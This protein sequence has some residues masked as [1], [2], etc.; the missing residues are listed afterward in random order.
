MNNTTQMVTAGAEFERVVTL[1]EEQARA[2]ATLAGDFNPI[3]HD[4]AFART[5]RFGGLIV[6]GTQT[7]ALMLAMTATYLSGFG[8]CLGLDAQFRFRRGIRMGETVRMV[9]RVASVTPK[10]GL[11][12][13]IK[14]TGTLTVVATNEVA[15]TGTSTGV[16]LRR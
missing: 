3:H 7:T 2:F 11:G 15:L 10:A 5:S 8:P 4:E 1:D 13:L 14:M 6:S 12:N 9:W 16:L